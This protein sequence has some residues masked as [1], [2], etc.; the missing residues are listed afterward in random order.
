MEEASRRRDE[1]SKQVLREIEAV[2]TQ[3]AESKQTGLQA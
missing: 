2:D 3:I 1:E